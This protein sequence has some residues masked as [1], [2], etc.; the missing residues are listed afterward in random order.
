M[1]YSFFYDCRNL[2]LYRNLCIFLRAPPADSLFQQNNQNGES[3]N[4][5]KTDGFGTEPIYGVP[6][7]SGGK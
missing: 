6:D 1:M 2:R 5:E 3:E 7:G 4:G